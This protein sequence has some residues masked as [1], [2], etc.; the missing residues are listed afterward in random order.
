M[1]HELAADAFNWAGAPPPTDR[2]LTWLWRAPRYCSVAGALAPPLHPSRGLPAG[3]PCSCRALSLTLGPW[4]TAM[5]G[6]ATS[7]VDDRSLK[8]RGADVVDGLL[9]TTEVLDHEFGFQENVGKRQRWQGCETAEHVGIRA[10]VGESARSP[11]LCPPRDGWQPVLDAARRV[12]AV[13]GGLRA[14]ELTLAMC[15]LPKWQWAAPFVA[16][17]PPSLDSLALRSVLRTGCTWWCDRRFWADRVRFHPSLGTAVLALRS[18][19]RVVG[20]QLWRAAVWAHA[21]TLGLEPVGPTA[22]GLHEHG[23]P[24][25]IRAHAALD[26]RAAEVVAAAAAASAG[27]PPGA[28]DAASSSGVH[29]LRVCARASLLQRRQRRPRQDEEGLERVCLQA[30]RSPTWSRY[31]DSLAGPQAVLLRVFRGGAAHT[32]TRRWRGQDEEAQ[33]ACP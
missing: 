27:A 31:R 14:R 25:W 15:V 29:V 3:C 17:P 2:F 16:Q 9:E 28:F 11:D 21:T 22:R 24:V 4:H 30:Q 32:P 20:S 10:A 33:R 13:P 19:G 8:A 5:T 26:N 18:A 7:Y 12:A 23:A 1:S 6:A